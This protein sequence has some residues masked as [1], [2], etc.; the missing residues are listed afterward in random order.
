[1]IKVRGRLRSAALCTVLA[2]LAIPTVL[3]PV[4]SAQTT[5]EGVALQRRSL[6]LRNDFAASFSHELVDGWH[7]FR[8]KVVK[9]EK[10]AEPTGDRRSGKHY[11]ALW[12]KTRFSD[13]NPPKN[14]GVRCLTSLAEK[15]VSDEWDG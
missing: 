15:A 9:V 14:R 12:I 8:W 11:F 5:S 13:G 7:V 2:S 10:S 4:I 3:A 1:M 6:G